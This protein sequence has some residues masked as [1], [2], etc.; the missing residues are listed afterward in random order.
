[1]HK[2]RVRPKENGGIERLILDK[3]DLNKV[4]KISAYLTTLQIADYFGICRDTFHAIRKRQ[5]EVD[6]RYQI[7][8][9]KKDLMYAQHLEDKAFGR[10]DKGDTTALIF[11]L[12]TQARWSE[13]PPEAAPA[14]VIT[15]TPEEKDARIQETKLYDLWKK[16]TGR[17]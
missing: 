13:A 4:E 5:P 17:R 11:Y 9:S 3:K 14:N 10:T 7:G 2:E 1:M 15:E 6:R 8:K 16:E 12:K